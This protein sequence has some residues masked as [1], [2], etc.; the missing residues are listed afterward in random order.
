M[1]NISNTKIDYL[2]L[3]VEFAD[4]PVLDDI[5]NNAPHLFTNVKLFALEIHAPGVGKSPYQIK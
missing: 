3:D 4:S 5:L 1:L 2:K